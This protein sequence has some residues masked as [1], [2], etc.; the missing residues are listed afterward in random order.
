MLK[1]R[2]NMENGVGQITTH[3][4]SGSSSC[5]EMFNDVFNKRWF[6][7]SD[8]MHYIIYQISS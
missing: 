4:K 8:D 7:L 2:L 6:T 1:L 3:A 5:V